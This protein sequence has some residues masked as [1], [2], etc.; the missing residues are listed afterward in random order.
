MKKILSILAMVIFVFTST[1]FS[2]EPGDPGCTESTTVGANLV[3]N[4]AWTFGNTTNGGF[5]NTVGNECATATGDK[6]SAFTGA[7][8]G[9]NTGSIDTNDTSSA[10]ASLV[11]SGKAT[12]SDVGNASI[13]GAGEVKEGSFVSKTDPN[14]AYY[15]NAGQLAGAKM[16][17]ITVSGS[18][19]PL[20]FNKTLLAGGVAGGSVDVPNKTFTVFANNTADGVSSANATNAIGGGFQ[21]PNAMIELSGSA[22]GCSSGGIV[23]TN[24]TGTGS[25]TETA[26]PNGFTLKASASVNESITRTASN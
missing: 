1:C 20:E 17:P 13:T 26:L 23:G 15:F 22:N 2:C 9:L 16:N 25:I 3:N 12:F 14:S 8:D 21:T 7:L 24:G 18:S 5:A 6:A 19:S 10:K 4:G 11:F